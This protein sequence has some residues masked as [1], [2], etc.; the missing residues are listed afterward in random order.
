MSSRNY[1]YYHQNTLC[2]NMSS[3][4]SSCKFYPIDSDIYT[5][6]HYTNRG[7]CK[8]CIYPGKQFIPVKPYVPILKKPK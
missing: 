2:S 3:V 7:P 1:S 5:V 8:Q 4:S 6:C